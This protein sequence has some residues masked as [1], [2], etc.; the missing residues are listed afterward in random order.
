VTTVAGALAELLVAALMLVGAG[1]ALVGS[2][3]LSKLPDLMTRLHAPTKAATLGLGCLLLA[4]LAADWLIAGRLSLHQVLITVF[5]FITAPVSALMIAKAHI[6]RRR[7][8]TEQPMTPSGRPVGW[9]T[10]DAPAPPEP[11]PAAD[12]LEAKGQPPLA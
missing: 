8:E 7:G 5:V 3:G 4:S 11:S 10:L 2:Y 12:R 1:F 6:F 9:A